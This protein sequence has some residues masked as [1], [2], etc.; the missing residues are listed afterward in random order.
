MMRNAITFK[1]ST[2]GSLH[3]CYHPGLPVGRGENREAAQVIFSDDW[4]WGWKMMKSMESRKS[5][6]H[7]N[8]RNKHDVAHREQYISTETLVIQIWHFKTVSW[9]IL[10][11]SFPM[12]SITT[13]FPNFPKDSAPSILTGSISHVRFHLLLRHSRFVVARIPTAG[14]IDFPIWVSPKNSKIAKICCLCFPLFLV[15]AGPPLGTHSLLVVRK[16]GQIY[17]V[18]EA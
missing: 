15:S 5:I 4:C 9:L 10:P 18:D 17:F 12:V 14:S 1:S 16:S 2:H 8:L 3:H 7:F 11:I 6:H 13:K